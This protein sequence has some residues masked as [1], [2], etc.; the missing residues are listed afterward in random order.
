MLKR[1]SILK[2]G[3]CGNIVEVLHIGGGTP[4]CCGQT[5]NFLEECLPS[6]FLDEL[7]AEDLHWAAKNPLSAEV[8]KNN[9]ESFFAGALSMLSEEL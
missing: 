7:P 1:N 6:R 4:T 5:M 8:K 2:C 3:V 9:K